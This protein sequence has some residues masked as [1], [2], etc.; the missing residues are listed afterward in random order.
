VNSIR[1]RAGPLPSDG[2]NLLSLD[3]CRVR[4]RANRKLRGMSNRIADHPPNELTGQDGRLVRT[5]KRHGRG[6]SSSF[7]QANVGGMFVVE[8]PLDVEGR[9]AV[10][11]V[12]P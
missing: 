1:S 6:A 8:N 12:A 3:T 2:L 4:K 11:G 10:V 7:A 9:G 5:Y